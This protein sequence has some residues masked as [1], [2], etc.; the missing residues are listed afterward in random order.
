MVHGEWDWKVPRIMR[1]D[2]VNGRAPIL[3]IQEGKKGNW[4]QR[5]G[6]WV[7]ENL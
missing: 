5:T 2:L 1:I 3:E 7:L 6:K 4:V